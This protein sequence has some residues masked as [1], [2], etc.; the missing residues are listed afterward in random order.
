MIAIIDY[1]IGNIGSIK[2]MLH[3]I[4]CRDVDFTSSPESLISADKII[5]PGVGS[6]D[7]GIEM[8][9]KSGMREELD[10]QVKKNKKPLLGICLG[11][12]MLGEKSD[13]GTLAGLGY[14]PFECKKF[15]FSDR[16]IKVPHM[17]WDYVNIERCDPIINGI[18]DQTRF[19]FV[20]SYYAKCKNEKNILLSCD[21]GI[22]FTAAVN[23]ENIYG[24][25]FHPEKSHGYGKQ[26]LRNFIE[27]V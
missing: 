15:V 17:G 14:I 22:R 8:L 2:N 27:E 4:G 7:A 18:S 20:H 26:F 19:Y 9:N 23:H 25:Q 3:K 12:Q 10:Y 5:L 24:V 11:M 16:G 21:Y 1:G 6:F 13:E